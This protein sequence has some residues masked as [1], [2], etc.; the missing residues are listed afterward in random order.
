MN[1]R[2]S[3]ARWLAYLSS[4]FCV[5]RWAIVSSTVCSVLRYPHFLQQVR[6]E[7]AA[8][9]H[10]M[11]TD[12]P[13]ARQQASCGRSRTKLSPWWVPRCS[14]DIDVDHDAVMSQSDEVR[15]QPPYSKMGSRRDNAPNTSSYCGIVKDN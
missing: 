11:L 4:A 6:G 7:Y 1:L 2:F 12:I 3:L 8:C 5:E 10:P 14:E 15:G 9:P 13:S